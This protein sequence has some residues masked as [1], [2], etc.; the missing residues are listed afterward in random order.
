MNMNLNAWPI[1]VGGHR[2]NWKEEDKVSICGDCYDSL[3]LKRQ[4]SLSSGDNLVGQWE[5]ES[6]PF[7]QTFEPSKLCL[8]HSTEATLQ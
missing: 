2:V 8:Q 5:A 1:V 6:R 4:D 7:S 3:M